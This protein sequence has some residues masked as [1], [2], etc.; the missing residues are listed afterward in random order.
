VKEPPLDEIAIRK[1]VIARARSR[2]SDPFFVPELGLQKGAAFLDLAVLTR[3]L[4]GFEFKSERDSLRRLPGQC[5]V[6]SRVLDRMTIVVAKRHLGNVEK[7]VPRWWAIDEVYEKH[8]HRVLR[9]IRRGGPNPA[10]D[11]FSPR[12]TLWQ[13]A[14]STLE[15]GDLRKA[16]RDQLRRRSGWRTRRQ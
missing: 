7:L 16:I 6:Y 4:H 1:A 12:H 8:G 15:L 5:D 13:R 2:F 3:E 10:V 11:P 9:S 14:A